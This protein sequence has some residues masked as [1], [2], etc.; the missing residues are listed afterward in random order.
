VTCP[1]CGAAMRASGLGFVCD[2]CQTVVVPDKGADGVQVMDE[3][4]DQE[5]PV[6]HVALKN[7]LLAGVGIEYCEKCRGFLVEMDSF[8]ALLA[9]V[10]VEQG[11]MIVAPSGDPRELE[12]KIACPRCQRTMEAHFYAGPGHVVMDS[13]EA[14]Q[15]NWMDAGEIERIAHAPSY[16]N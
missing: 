8:P 12:R 7:A 9:A 11:A 3:V 6:C 5:C 14:C 4:P 10:R 1:A 15:V 2:Y 16:V 13:C